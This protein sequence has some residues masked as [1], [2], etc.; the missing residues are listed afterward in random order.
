MLG[1]ASSRSKIRSTGSRMRDEVLSS[2]PIQHLAQG[3]GVDRGLEA[4]VQ[5]LQAPQQSWVAFSGRVRYGPGGGELRGVYSH[6][7]H[8]RA[9]C[10]G[11]DPSFVEDV[12]GIVF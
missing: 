1:A 10:D 12:V 8:D 4:R 6:E 9:A 11:R 7:W 3:S 2:E 5:Q